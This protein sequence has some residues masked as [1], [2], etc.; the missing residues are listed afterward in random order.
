MKRTTKL[1][2]LTL[3]DRVVKRF[4]EPAYIQD[5][6]L[7]AFQEEG[8]PP[9]IDD[10]LPPADGID[11]KERLSAAIERLNKNQKDAHM[12]FRGNGRGTG[13]RWERLAA[14]QSGARTGPGRP[15]KRPASP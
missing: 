11:A 6:I 2:E 15:L 5:L 9:V 4:Q 7:A 3:D 14:T 12:I 1:R 13:I 8:W 10:P